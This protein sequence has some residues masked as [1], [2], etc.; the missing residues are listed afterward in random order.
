M[1]APYMPV[2]GISQ[3]ESSGLDETREGGRLGRTSN[4]VVQALEDFPLGPR[5][6]K[7][8]VGGLVPREKTERRKDR[9]KQMFKGRVRLCAF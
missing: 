3:E 7:R 5:S 6:R 9:G 1:A 2:S 8:G 4:P